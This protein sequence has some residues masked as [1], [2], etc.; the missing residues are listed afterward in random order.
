M[1]KTLLV[2]SVG[3]LC[4]TVVT[5]CGQSGNATKGPEQLNMAIAWTGAPAKAVQSLLDTY[6]KSQTK[7]HWNLVTNVTEEK[8]LAEEAA[9]NAPSVAMLNTTNLVATMATKGAI[10]PLQP[11]IQKSHFDMSQFTHAS[12]YSNSLLG[13]QYALPFFEDTY[14]LYYNKA[15]FKQAGIKNPPTTLNELLVDAKKLTVTGSNGQYTQL[16][17]MPSMPKELEAYLWGGRWA[18]PSGAITATDPQTAQGVQWLVNVWKQFD[19]K[20]VQRFIAGSSGA[21]GSIDPF[22]VG[23]V[24]MEVSGE[25]FMPTIM[26]ESPNMDF[27]VAPIPYPDGNPQYKDVGSVGGNPLVILKGTTDEQASWALIQWL[28]TKGEQLGVQPKL[29]NEIY[30]VPALKS[31]VEDSKL[32]PTPQ[33]AFFWKYSEGNNIIPFA[34]VPDATAYLTA[35]DSAVQKAEVANTPVSTALQQVQNQYAPLIAQELKTAGTGS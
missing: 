10:L 17:F 30:A 31:L 12:L 3:A 13:Q 4:S 16:G 33:M 2:L 29:F 32:A 9:G 7:V 23:K 35:I 5:A 11:L 8:L 19:A 20:K 25:W 21:A 26:Q 15:L 34:P 28:S 22:A 27:G 14:A 24:G 18:S 6:N 1:R